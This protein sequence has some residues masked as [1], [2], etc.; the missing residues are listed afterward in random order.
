MS[1]LQKDALSECFCN[2]SNWESLSRACSRVD[3]SLWVVLLTEANFLVETNAAGGL[4]GLE[5]LGV[6][7]NTVLLLESL[8][9][10]DISHLVW[11]E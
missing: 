7:E 3:L 5:L 1:G 2:L 6:E 8:L 10:L 4:L 11:F 9:V